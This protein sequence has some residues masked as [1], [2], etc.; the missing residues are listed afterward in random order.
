MNNRLIHW[1]YDLR[2]YYT[3]GSKYMAIIMGTI[4]LMTFVGV[5]LK[6]SPYKYAIII[7]GIMLYFGTICT[8]GFLEKRYGLIAREY[9][10]YEEES[11]MN[12]QMLKKLESIEERLG[13]HDL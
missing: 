9:N 5:W 3:F 12:K 4:Q 7:I 10:K 2:I 13:E 8:M 1:F 11:E 6:N